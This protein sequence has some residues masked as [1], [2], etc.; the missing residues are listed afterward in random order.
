MNR[1]WL[2]SG[3]CA[4]RQDQEAESLYVIISGRIRL[5]HEFQHTV[6]GKI[7]LKTEEEVGRGEAIGAVWAITG[8]QHDST[9]LCV[10]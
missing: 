1:V 5:L 2:K 7:H 4:Y 9:S 8:G 3:D 6:S 10:R